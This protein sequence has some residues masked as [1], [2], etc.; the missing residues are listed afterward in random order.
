[1]TPLR[2]RMIQDMELHGLSKTTQHTYVSVVKNFAEHFGRSPA[3]IGQEDIRRFFIHL[4]KVRRLA[5]STVRVYLFAIKFLY[6]RTLQR[7]WPVLQL[8]RVRNVRKFPVVLSHGEVCDLLRKLRRPEARMSATL[9][10]CCGLRVSEATKLQALDIDSRRM[11]VCVRNGK[12]AKDRNVPLPRRVLQQLR[13]YWRQHRPGHWLFPS[14]TGKTPISASVVRQAIKAA[15][16]QAGIVKNVSCHTLRHSY[17][18]HL[19]EKRV[20]LRIIQ[21][22]LGHRSP[23][24]TVIYTHLTQGT[25]KVVHDAVNDL[26]RDF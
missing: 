26:T 14:K 18:T 12:G 5:R 1:M 10:Y 4:T 25:I 16:L 11:V 17:A 9:M 21:G 7:Q 8:I 15:A 6:R 20:D 23:R 19:L 2:R 22:M 24:S 3:R 13:Q